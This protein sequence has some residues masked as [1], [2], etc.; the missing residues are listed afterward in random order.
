MAEN[1]APILCAD[2]N[3]VDIE[4]FRVA[5][6]E[7]GLNYPLEVV[8]DGQEALDYL[9]QNGAYSQQAQVIPAAILLDIKMPRLNGIEALKIIRAN[10]MLIHVPVIMLTSSEMLKDIEVCYSLGANAYVVKPIDFEEFIRKVESMSK[11]WQ[12][13]NTMPET[14]FL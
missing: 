10:P 1:H 5:F 9:H 13:L 7:I 8:R 2:D 12:Y 4:L 14:A 11:F 6:E 3:P